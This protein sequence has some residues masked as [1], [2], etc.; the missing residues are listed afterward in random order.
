M[1]RDILLTLIDP[2]P[3]NA[4]QTFDESTIA[5]LAQS[6]DASGLAVPIMLR[7]VGDRFTIVH[8]ERR[9]RAVKSLDWQTIPADVH[10]IDADAASWLGLV[11]NVQR[12]D[13]SPIEEAKAYQAKLSTGITQSELGRRIGKT[14]SHIATKLRFL[15]LPTEV[16]QALQTQ[17][18]SEGHAKQL[19][20]LKSDKARLK[21]CEN[22]IS[23]S[24]SVAALTKEVDDAIELERLEVIIQNGINDLDKIDKD[25]RERDFIP[26]TPEALV[27]WKFK[28]NGSIPRHAEPYPEEHMPDVYAPPIEVRRININMIGRAIYDWR[29]QRNDEVGEWY[30]KILGT[31]PPIAVYQDKHGYVLA[32]GFYRLKAAVLSGNTDI[33]CRVYATPAGEVAKRTAFLYGVAANSMHGMNSLPSE[34]HIRDANFR[35]MKDRMTKYVT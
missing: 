21:M 15:T 13:L 22:V 35:K 23:L 5:E 29:D 26:D 6:I 34:K 8:G 16:Q 18:I 14:Q 32:D 25:W 33:E 4:R 20:R 1:S 11:E 31:M 19:L 24:L 2:D 7:P 17:V 9:F 30:A 27:W 28:Q 10:D 3:N 12:A